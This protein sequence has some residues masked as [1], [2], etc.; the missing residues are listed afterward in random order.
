MNHPGLW[1]SGRRSWP[2]VAQSGC[3]DQGDAVTLARLTP[4]LSEWAQ[5]S[6]WVVL[7][8]PPAG[9]WAELLSEAGIVASRVLRVRC[10]DD[11]EA[12]WALEQSLLSGTCAAALAWLPTL[13]HRDKR[14]LQLVQKRAHCPA[15]LFQPGREDVITVSNSIH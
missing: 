10:G 15:V 4:A 5:Q 9:H 2:A 1:Q 11:V 14:R 12:L 6:G 7:I 8:N 3:S 13:D